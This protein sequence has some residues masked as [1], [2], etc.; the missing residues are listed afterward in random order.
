MTNHR[1]P[2][3]VLAANGF[4]AVAGMAFGLAPL[5]FLKLA[6]VMVIICLAVAVVFFAFGLRTLRRRLTRVEVSD[7]GIR[8]SGAGNIAFAWRDLSVMTFTYYSTRRDHA[9]GWMEINLGGRGRSIRIDS[10]IEGFKAIVGRAATAARQNRIDLDP[11]TR[12]NLSASGIDTAH[13]AGQKRE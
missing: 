13:M 3:S 9:K 11:A 6:P 12:Q 10:R 2:A 8:L 7:D 5:T 1:Y 4:R